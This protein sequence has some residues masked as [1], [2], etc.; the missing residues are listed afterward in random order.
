MFFWSDLKQET[1][2]RKLCGSQP[3]ATALVQG[4]KQFP[5]IRGTVSF[6]PVDNKG[7]LVSCEFSGLPQR[8]GTCGRGIHGL[9]VHAG[10]SCTGSE[11]DPF[12]NAGTHFNPYHCE[13]PFHAGDLLPIMEN[14]GFAWSAFYTE[15][16]RVPDVIGKTV[17]LH[18]NPDDF[19]TQPAGDSGIKVACGVIKRR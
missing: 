16:F 15:R 5:S 17:V 19:K 6:Y 18:S 1:I 2:I 12:L 14:D 11:E 13:H 10:T 4:S 7:V 8:A 3:S 9:H